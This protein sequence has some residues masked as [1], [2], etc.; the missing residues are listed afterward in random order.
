MF[1]PPEFHETAPAQM[2]RIIRA[3]PLGT[4]V[5][6]TA[7]GIDA[8]HIPFDLQLGKSTD[9]LTAH[10]ARLNPLAALLQSE[11]DVLVIFRGAQGYISP[12]WYPNKQITHRFVP[13]WNY[14]V[15]H[16]HGRM[17]LLDDE[18][19]KRGL[20]ARL[21]RV[22]ESNQSKPWKMGDAPADYL[23]ELLKAIVGIEI[24]VVRMECVRKMSQNR[25][26]TDFQGAID[27]LRDSGQT[28]LAN[29]ML[30]IRNQ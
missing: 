27:G 3:F 16:V 5:T 1:I 24:Q 9:V 13:T 14:E 25:E 19:F 17:Q 6:H 8:D 12:S 15:V 21:T 2:H 18:R 28:S 26:D 29:A 22:H 23:D 7:H 20:L 30:E 10:I 11:M 4:L